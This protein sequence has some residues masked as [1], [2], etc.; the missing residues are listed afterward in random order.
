M[1]NNI[2]KGNQRIDP[3]FR[4]LEN[5]LQTSLK[6]VSPRPD[7]VHDLRQQLN[8]Q[9]S[10]LPSLSQLSHSNAV[11]VTF[12]LILCIILLIF[13]SVRAAVTLIS[14]FSLLYQYRRQ[15]HVKQTPHLT[16]EN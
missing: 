4:H 8:G 12:G 5:K 15:A 16:L 11:M 6:P 9:F 10:R 1:K 2:A 14:A 7:F 3:D 13:F